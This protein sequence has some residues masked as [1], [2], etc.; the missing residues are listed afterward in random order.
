MSEDDDDEQDASMKDGGDYS[1]DEYDHNLSVSSM[2]T[3]AKGA[4]FND[5]EYF[6]K[7]TEK[8]QKRTKQKRTREIDDLTLFSR[9]GMTRDMKINELKQ[10]L[11]RFNL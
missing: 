11:E 9:P 4:A 10:K 7:R 3:P 8:V 1:S 2:N 6:I 5:R